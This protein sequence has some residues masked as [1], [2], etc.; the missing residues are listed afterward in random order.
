MKQTQPKNGKRRKT[1]APEHGYHGFFLYIFIK[2]QYSIGLQNFG[3]I[4]T[5]NELETYIKNKRHTE[6]QCI[7]FIFWLNNGENPGKGDDVTFLK[8]DFWNC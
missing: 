3:A 5:D 7:I 8:V 4:K 1:E 2:L 6:I